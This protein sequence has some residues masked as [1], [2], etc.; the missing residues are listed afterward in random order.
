[1]DER[2]QEL[3]TILHHIGRIETELRLLRQAVQVILSHHEGEDQDIILVDAELVNPDEVVDQPQET[4]QER[5]TVAPEGP[6]VLTR[7]QLLQEGRWRA[8][9]WAIQ[10]R[11][12][13]VEREEL[14]RLGRTARQNRD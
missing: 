9:N 3:Q 10:E 2:N 8:Q 6:R 7:Q 5:R 4:V 12:A 13:R 14:E 11:A 1:M